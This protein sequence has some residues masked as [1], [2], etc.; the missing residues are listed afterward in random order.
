[1]KLRGHHLFCT[2]L[3]SG[4]GY[5]ASFT[6]KMLETVNKLESGET[7]EL[8]A[9]ADDL[10]AACPHKL[11]TGGC[12]LGTEDVL[13]R[14]RAAFHVL[15]VSVGQNVSG[16]EAAR[17]LLNLTEEAFQQVCGGCRWQEEGL[18]SWELLQH[19]CAVKL[20]RSKEG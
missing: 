12:A 9:R 5:S 16:A 1:M 2:A 17:R 10:C 6:Q 11:S 20:S 8:Q 14:D 7:A 4:Y 13:R 3:F 18:C 15:G 19:V